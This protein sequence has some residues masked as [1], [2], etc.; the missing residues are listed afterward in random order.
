MRCAVGVDVSKSKSTVAIMNEK[1]MLLEKVFEIANNRSGIAELLKRLEKYSDCETRVI[2]EA[3]SY[4]HFPVLFSL[5]EAGCFVTVANALA[6]K[7]FCDED[8]RRAKNDRKDA[9]KLAK[10]CCEKWERLTDFHLCDEIRAEMLFLSREYDKLMS[11]QTKLKIQLTELIDKTFAGMK[12][13]VDAE[14]RYRLLLDIYEKYW[15]MDKAVAAG[16]EK[17]VKDIETLA[18]KHG[19]KVG[20]RIGE[21]LFDAAFDNVPLRP[22]NS[23][24]KLAVKSCVSMLRQVLKATAEIITEMERLAKKLPEYE[25]VSQMSG[26]GIKTRARLIAEIGDVN[27]FKTA[28]S[29]IAFC[30]I[31]TPP[32]QSGRFEAQ[33]RRITKRGNKHLRKIGYEIM[34]NLKICKPKRDAKVYEYIVKK[35]LEG[36]AKKAAKIAGLNKFLRIYYK[37]VKEICSKN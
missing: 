21:I 24:T 9:V 30:G 31:D 5:K 15:H 6:V 11:T 19:H 17:F 33:N 4:Y 2:M 1:E 7:K 23:V 27:R 22:C 25:V 20:K 26:T 3:T 32:Y 18:K 16:K 29:L 35:E 37:R 12:E 14:S 36:K 34:R 28:G 10:Y 13:A 8:L